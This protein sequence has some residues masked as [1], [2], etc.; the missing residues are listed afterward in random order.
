[1]EGDVL[2]VSCVCVCILTPPS[3]HR[4]S[5]PVRCLPSRDPPFPLRSFFVLLF[6][7]LSL[8]STPLAVIFTSLDLYI[9]SFLF[10]FEEMKRCVVVV[11]FPLWLLFF[12]LPLCRVVLRCRFYDE[13]DDD[14][15]EGGLTYLLHVP[16]FSLERFMR[17]FHCCCSLQFYSDEAP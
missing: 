17:V 16:L 2:G 3:V 6:S 7:L 10:V 12:F 1:V 5:F 11:V 13:G 15:R 14:G 9:L 8:F 4:C